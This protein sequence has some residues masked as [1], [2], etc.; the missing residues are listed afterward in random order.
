MKQA[1]YPKQA[2]D[3]VRS[4]TG[5]TAQHESHTN[6]VMPGR[7]EAESNKNSRVVENQNR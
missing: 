1:M 5:T 7:S 2:K 6:R 4:A 3:A